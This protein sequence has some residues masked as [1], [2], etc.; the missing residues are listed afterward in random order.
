[1]NPLLEVRD[2]V[3]SNFSASAFHQ[4]WLSVAYLD[5]SKTSRI[6]G[7]VTLT[8]FQRKVYVPRLH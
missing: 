5:L 1:M 3:W 6:S 7:H 4:N 2:R 8:K